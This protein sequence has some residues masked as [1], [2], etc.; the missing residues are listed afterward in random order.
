M[1]ATLCI[2]PYSS[3]FLYPP[4]LTASMYA[5]TM[6]PPPNG[7]MYQLAEYM[8]PYGYLGWN[9]GFRADGLGGVCKKS[10]ILAYTGFRFVTTWS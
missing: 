5:L 9:I 1:Y 8:E 2:R 6:F 10:R 4:V 7:Q 3:F